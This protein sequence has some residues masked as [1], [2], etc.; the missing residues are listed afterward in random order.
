MTEI[1]ILVPVYN[2]EKY[3]SA[4][5]DS[6][7]AQ[8]FT[9]FEVICM[10][11][12]STDRSGAILDAYA[13]KDS[14]IKVIHK[15]NSGYGK[16]MNMALSKAEGRYI[17]I[18]ESDDTIEMDMYQNLYKA[19]A[20]YDLDFVKADFY[21]VW[22]NEDGTVQKQYFNLT[23]DLTMYNRVLNPNL[24]LDSYL[25][26][27]FTWNALYR[28]ELLLEHNI[29]YNETPG[30]SFQDN[31][32]WFQTFYWAK[33]AMFLDKA[34]YNYRQDNMLSSVH[35]RKKVYAMKNEFDF[36]RSFMIKHSDTPEGL[37]P[38]CFH[39]R[40]LA[41]IGTLQRIDLSLKK[42]FAKVIAKERDFYQEQNEACYDYMTREQI[43]IIKNP[44][45][46]VEDVLIQYREITGDVI[47]GYSNVIVYGAGVHGERIVYRVKEAKADNQTIK[48]AVTSLNGRNIVCQGET[49][50][51][52][53]DCVDDKGS[54]L[55]ILAVKENSDAF[56]EM[57]DCLKKYMFPHIIS[58]S[59]KR[60]AGD[61]NG[62]GTGIN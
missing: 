2:V 41:Y 44:I 42:E 8:T 48:V 13:L 6:I 16:T 61:E 18:V 56:Y 26:K 36:I 19:V 43:S 21:A 3:L 14:R 59:A 20:E 11:D 30:A 17:G 57:L 4:C 37:Y 10:D 23:D 22:D 29:R 9:D 51:E 27:K 7:L 54:S 1:S 34:V 31:G 52:I 60:L 39:L 62:T 24:E 35:D 28:K 5:I 40:M 58:E 15:E 45:G 50:C 49:V 46:Y 38:I 25:L 33:R 32:F 53:S 55:V 12:G 47:S